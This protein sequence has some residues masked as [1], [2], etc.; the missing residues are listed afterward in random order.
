MW[1]V[2]LRGKG[3]SGREAEG[4]PKWQE[5]VNKMDPISLTESSPKLHSD[6]SC[7]KLACKGL[8]DAPFLSFSCQL[9]SL[10]ILLSWEPI[11]QTWLTRHLGAFLQ[12]KSNTL[13]WT[14]GH[15]CVKMFRHDPVWFVFTLDF[16]QVQS[17]N[18]NYIPT[19]CFC[20]SDVHLKPETNQSM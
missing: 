17:T 8:I 10:V 14:K 3:G 18:S 20:Q 1:K 12:L 9:D 11:E 19:S 5:R 4:I 16:V 13:V 7:V 15:V 6:V 2:W